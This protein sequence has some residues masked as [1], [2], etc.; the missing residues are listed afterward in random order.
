MLSITTRETADTIFSLWYDPTENQTQST[1]L[2]GE[3]S[4]HEAG[5]L[6]FLLITIFK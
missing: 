3:R 4:S 5:N 2:A 6:F 1:S